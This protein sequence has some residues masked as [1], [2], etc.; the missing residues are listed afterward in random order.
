[1]QT[2]S[3]CTYKNHQSGEIEFLFKLECAVIKLAQT[4]RSVDEF[5]IDTLVIDDVSRCYSLA[6]ALSRFVLEYWHLSQSR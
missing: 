5:I 1:M 6:A 4:E 3:I 2:D